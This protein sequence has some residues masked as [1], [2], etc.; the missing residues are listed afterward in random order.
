MNVLDV[1][2]VNLR[3]LYSTAPGN[4]TSMAGTANNQ[5]AQVAGT[6]DNG[7][8]SGSP[9]VDRALSI[10]NQGNA[11]IGAVVFLVMLLGLMIL[12]KRFGSEGGSFS[13]IQLSAYNVVIIGL[14]AIVGV[15][16]WKWIFTRFPI[17][18]VS[19]WVHSV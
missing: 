15:P 1:N 17:P 13:N 16:V 19:T 8:P 3:N 4:R 10:G 9:E 5:T 18:G 6:S 2:S 12:A 11:V 14:A 7:S